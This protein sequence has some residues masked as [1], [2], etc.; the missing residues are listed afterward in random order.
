MTS[1]LPVLRRDWSAPLNVKQTAAARAVLTGLSGP[2]WTPVQYENLAR[3]G[4]CQ[5]VLVYRCV[6][7]IAGACSGI[8]WNLYQRYVRSKR[9][10]D[11]RHPLLQL[12]RKPNEMQTGSTF[13]HSVIGY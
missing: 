7:A 8:A 10:K 9:E 11:P 4:Y 5:N 6:E 1:H 2:V 12:L 3:E 13:V